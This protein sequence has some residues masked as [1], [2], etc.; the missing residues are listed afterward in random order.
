MKFRVIPLSLREANEFVEKYHRHHKKVQGHKFSIGTVNEKGELCGAAIVG[1]PVARMLDDGLTLE[2]TRLCTDGTKNVC[3]FLYAACRRIA[4][5][6]GY[7]KLVT[8]VLETEP[9]ISLKAAGWKCVG[10]AGGG[11][12]NRPN[13]GRY[14]EDKHPICRKIR[15]EVNLA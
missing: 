15:W 13:I 6:M 4:K 14:R 10:L 9:G 3:S 5:E 2:V 1:R 7:R 12:W 11:T 8:Y